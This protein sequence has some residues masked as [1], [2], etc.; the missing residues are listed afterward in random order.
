[1]SSYAAWVPDAQ[2]PH[3]L[4]TVAENGYS[5]DGRVVTVRFSDGGIGDYREQHLHRYSELPL[6]LRQ[7]V[8]DPN[9]QAPVPSQ[10]ARTGRAARTASERVARIQQEAIDPNLTLA[11]QK[12]EALSEKSLT[13]K[14]GKLPAR[15]IAVVTPVKDATYDLYVTLLD[16]GVV[17]RKRITGQDILG[18]ASVDIEQS[19]DGTI[20]VAAAEPGYGYLLY[21]T[22]ATLLGEVARYRRGPGATASLKGSYSQTKYAKRFWSRQPGG[23]V[24]PLSEADFKRQFGTTYTSLTQKGDRLA[25]RVAKAYGLPLPEAYRDIRMKGSSYFSDYYSVSSRASQ[26]GPSLVPRPASPR[27]TVATFQRRKKRRPVERNFALVLSEVYSGSRLPDTYLVEVPRGASS[28]QPENV[29]ARVA[30]DDSYIARTVE[31]FGQ[32]GID[33]HAGEVYAQDIRNRLRA[34]F[35]ASETPANRRKHE[36]MLRRGEALK[37]SLRQAGF[38]SNQDIGNLFSYLGQAASTYAGRAHEIEQDTPLLVA[39]PRRFPL[40]VPIFM[41]V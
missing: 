4:G 21:A 22:A 32:F 10:T 38:T 27:E 35:K 40:S 1:M 17:R 26:V 2:N 30:G 37:T 19:G 25:Q 7:V 28:L 41:P 6:R 9:V 33:Y 23:V 12:V 39:N 13:V 24:A 5:F 29:L 14:K 15:A 36:R 20:G 31:V 16:P 34:L 18:H 3:P 11:P 8:P